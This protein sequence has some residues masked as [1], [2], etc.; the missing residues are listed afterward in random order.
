MNDNILKEKISLSKA[1]T[2]LKDGI[3][4]ALSKECRAY[5]VVPVI[6]NILILSLFGYGLFSYINKLIF[7]IFQAVPEFL[8][9]LAY[10]ISGIVMLM[11]IFVGCYFF[12][13]IATIIASP[14]YGLLS[15]K[16][17][18]K[19][20]NSHGDDMSIID[21][22]KD[23]PRILKRE[24]RK[25]LFFL[26]LALICLIIS[27]IPVVNL[28]SPIL[29]FLLTSWMGC[30]Q[31]CDYAYDNHKVAFNDMHKD[32]KDNKLPTFIIGA[33][34]A[35]G[36]SIPIL[37]IIIPPAAV[38]AGTKYYVEIQKHFRLV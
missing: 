13:T 26:P 21:I 27:F 7:D 5:L 33:T 37:N 30:L 1:L 2:Y 12:S 16:V 34:I 32:L 6:I 15:D 36:L 9:F 29:W 18:M 14:F 38:C 23:I 10:V 25:Q 4:I 31:Y 3:S 28:I 20:N 17:E 22:I 19:L 24:L 11:I 35:I 8:T